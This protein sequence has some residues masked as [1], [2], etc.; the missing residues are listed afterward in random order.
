MGESSDGVE[1][2]PGRVTIYDRTN[3][4]I[5]IGVAPSKM[6]AGDPPEVEDARSFALWLRDRNGGGVPP[7]SLRLIT[8]RVGRDGTVLGPT[9]TE[10]ES[11]FGELYQR[12]APSPRGGLVNTR[13]TI[14]AIG[15][16]FG[17]R[18]GRVSLQ[19]PNDPESGGR[20]IELTGI[21]DQFRDSGAF[22][23]VVLI[24][25]VPRVVGHTGTSAEIRLPQRAGTVP[26]RSAASFY[27]FSNRY[28]LRK[29]PSS[30][31]RF[32]P[33]V[34]AGLEGAARDATG[35]VSSLSLEKFLTREFEETARADPAYAP[36]CVSSGAIIIFSRAPRRVTGGA[37]KRAAREAE[38]RGPLTPDVTSRPAT[39]DE[40]A[41]TEPRAG[42]P[43]I[44]SEAP[45]GR[46]GTAAAGEARGL[47]G[48]RLKFVREAPEDELCLDV[49]DYAN[50]VAQL[51]ASADEGE[52]CLAVFGPW[53]RGKTFL[54]RKV[55]EALC[56][57]GRGYRTIRFSAWKYP[58]APE[59]WVHLYEEFAK[60]AF[61]GPWYRS[62]PNVVRAGLSKRGAWPL[63]WAY[64]I[65]AFGLIPLGTVF[66][67]ARAV[68]VALYPLIGV[69][70][71]VLLAT[72]FIGARRTQARLTR[73]YLT[74]SR[75]AEKL[76]LQ[77]TIGSDLRALLM[78][79]IPDRPFGRGFVLWYVAIT[80]VLI[81]AALLRLS[82][83]AE[84]EYLTKTY[85]GRTVVGGAR[86]GVEIALVIGTAALFAGLLYWLGAG[87]DSPRRIL[88]VV[89]DL[90][91]CKPEHLLSVMESIK[92]LIEDPEISRR[93]Q[94]AM[95]LEEDVF[96][97]AIFEKYG[98]L[99]DKSRARLLHTRYDADQ[100]IWDNGEK[101]FMAHLRLP[102]LA[103]SELREVIE[104]FSG[105]R[106]ER[107]AE[108]KRRADREKYLREEIAREQRREPATHEQTGTKVTHVERGPY[109]HA[110][111]TGLERREEPIYRERTAEEMERDRKEHEERLRALEEELAG[112]RTN[113]K[114][115]TTPAQASEGAVTRS[116]KV[117]EGPEIDAILAALDAQTKTRRSLGPRAI[118][119]FMFRYQLA[120]LLLYT[121]K[122]SWEPETLAR[123][124][125]QRSF[126]GPAGAPAPVS[127][128]LSDEQKVQRVVDQVC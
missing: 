38:E 22:D 67:A 100:L 11:A 26:E 62:T 85:L 89:D 14:V 118:R 53:G 127:A 97:H 3:A 120:R 50:A 8:S 70:G 25:D 61:A 12:P 96:K 117:L 86:C 93:V 56:A 80:A 88:L 42:G 23:E 63:L 122:I 77:A 104:T 90:D 6:A 107:A 15:P 81:A 123:L 98:H 109:V 10:I 48:G 49:Q 18:G 27:L 74:A 17:D 108:L 101:L 33:V 111:P 68:F 72:I 43:G 13:L 44:E 31:R 75:H 64:A 110:E 95:L 119:A 65:F 79:W 59:V 113:E 91:R 76:G 28:G 121:L 19:L 60:V 115:E 125:A 30:A 128:D 126:G 83:G 29:A 4:A 114:P 92:L 54:M 84:I 124:L 66:S 112:L 7:R 46:T 55:D 16:G 51:Y 39:P 40:G 69:I 9:F 105:R 5:V 35:A 102:T 103:R 1:G 20:A 21:A 99:L 87:G 78:G 52:F 94:V 2:D 116:P 34:R 71:F 41:R 37:R 45:S 73:D 57:L 58:S 106:G 47:F 24:A 82:Q 36:E 32:I